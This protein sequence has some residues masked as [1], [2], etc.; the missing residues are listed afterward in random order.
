MERKVYRILD[1]YFPSD[2]S[3][4]VYNYYKNDRPIWYIVVQDCNKN[5]PQIYGPWLSKN[6]A[7]MYIN[8]KTTKYEFIEDYSDDFII[9]EMKDKDV[10]KKIFPE[11]YRFS[12]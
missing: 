6:D 5:L 11:R 1:G 12:T 10:Y 4:I 2:I 9:Y 3:D 8:E 7:I